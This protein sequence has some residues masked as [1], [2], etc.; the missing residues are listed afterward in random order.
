MSFL[1]DHNCTILSFSYLCSLLYMSYIIEC[2]ISHL[3]LQRKNLRNIINFSFSP[4]STSK[5]LS[6]RHLFYHLNQ[7]FHPVSS[8]FFFC[9]FSLFLL[10]LSSNITTFVKVIFLKYISAH[11]TCFKSSVDHHPLKSKFL[12]ST[13]EH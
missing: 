11:V 2:H 13:Q 12:S 10:S 8:H 7:C 6:V 1:Y 5:H 3:N 4:I 9:M